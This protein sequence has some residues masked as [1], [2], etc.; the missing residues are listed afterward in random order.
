MLT[1]ITGFG[2]AIGIGT[3]VNG[4]FWG[5]GVDVVSWAA[6]SKAANSQRA[7]KVLTVSTRTPSPPF[8][9]VLKKFLRASLSLL[10]ASGK[11]ANSS[12]YAFLTQSAIIVPDNCRFR[13]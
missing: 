11:V 7:L 6:L 13:Y 10:W 9:L 8:I 2:T 3:F 5:S 4:A 1:L 12:E